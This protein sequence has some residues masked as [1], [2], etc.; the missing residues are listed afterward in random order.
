[1]N[2]R[3]MI[4][5]RWGPGRGPASGLGP[6]VGGGG[7]FT[8]IELIVTLI[9]AG[10]LMGLMLPTLRTITRDWR[11]QSAY[12]TVAA[13]V[14]AARLYATRDILDL[15]NAEISEP[16]PGAKYSGAAVVFTPAGELR[17]VEND[18][19]ARDGFGNEYIETKGW[20]GYKDLKGI[21]YLRLPVGTG[22]VGIGKPDAPFYAPP[23]AI[24]FDENGVL[25][26]GVN[27]AS[28]SDDKYHRVVIYDDDFNGNY[29]TTQD[30]SQGNYK[31]PDPY[32]PESRE[33]AN[34]WDATI[35]K[36]KL[37]FEQLE[38]VIGVIVYSKADFEDAG[39]NWGSSSEEEIREWL[40]TPG[41][42]SVMLFS[43][44]TGVVIRERGRR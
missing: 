41:N 38:T 42:G 5:A 29:S 26:A 4:H 11:V 27:G 32:D 6:G 20:N 33:W 18:Q 2:L 14:P 44:Y 25:I 24:R 7:G 40:R 8:I 19:E 43:R 39:L 31:D 22:V 28:T 3:W 30:R 16:I 13:A 12:N 37:P 21:D 1:M 35:Q 36:Y 9:I 17:L 10:V 34:N 23:F 15:G